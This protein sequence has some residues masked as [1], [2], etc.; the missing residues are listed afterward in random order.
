[1]GATAQRRMNRTPRRPQVL[2]ALA[3][4]LP[5]TALIV[6]AF[7]FLGE[8]AGRAAAEIESEARSLARR[9]AE[10]VAARLEREAE[11][12][13]VPLA[14]EAGRIEEEGGALRFVLERSSSGAPWAL[15]D[16]P[17]P[18]VELAASDTTAEASPW[19]LFLPGLEQLEFALADPMN[20]AAQYERLEPAA[21]SRSLGTRMLLARAG[22][23]RRAGE[24]EQA[25]TVLQQLLARTPADAALDGL[26]LHSAA[27][28]ELIDLLQ[29]ADRSGESEES[30]ALCG[31]ISRRTGS[32]CRPGKWRR[33]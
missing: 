12:L 18:C 28:L 30:A 21:G 5:A 6:V 15:A 16:G 22:A 4:L 19:L 11:A 31:A 9:T 26:P 23:L 13:R 8:R 2:A 29:R 25:A 7:V 14:G 3:S 32:L 17:P 27:R 20:A 24:P 33:I 1:M 10:R